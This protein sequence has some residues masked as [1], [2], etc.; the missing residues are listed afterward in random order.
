MSTPVVINTAAIQYAYG[1]TE[2]HC[3]ETVNGVTGQ[4][5][6][7]FVTVLDSTTLADDWTDADLCAAVAA[8]LNIP[9]ADV[10]VAAAPAPAPTPEPVDPAPADPV[11]P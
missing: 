2:C 4:T 1:T 6:V 5:T 9:A 3:V 10:S 11:V 7:S 8:K